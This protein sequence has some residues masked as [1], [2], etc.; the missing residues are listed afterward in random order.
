[1][2]KQFSE[3]GVQA[4]PCAVALGEG[5]AVKLT[6]GL[7]VAA[8][9]A[10]DK[11]LGVTSVANDAGQDANVRLRSSPGTSFGRAGGNIA[12]G[13]YVTATTAGELIATTT[14]GNEIV[15]MALETAADDGFFK[16]INWTGTVKA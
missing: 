7:I 3:S 8:T 15:G 10:T 1:M 9:A 13:D 5:V 2:S 14:A 4:F 16:F 6:A 12:V 11:I